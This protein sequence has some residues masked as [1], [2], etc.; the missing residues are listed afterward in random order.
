MG[1]ADASTPSTRDAKQVDVAISGGFWMS[2][3][4]VTVGD[5]S[6]ARHGRDKPLRGPLGF[7]AKS[8]PRRADTPQSSH[9]RATTLF[10]TLRPGIAGKPDHHKPLAALNPPREL[11]LRLPAKA[12]NGVSR[13]DMDRKLRDAGLLVC[14]V[15]QCDNAFYTPRNGVLV[16]VPYLFVAAVRPPR[17]AEGA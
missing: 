12:S 9:P 10:D 15:E 2:K 7:V 8:W 13:A 11:C 3:Y 5:Y 6:R 1:L 16:P 4:E 17:G 14:D